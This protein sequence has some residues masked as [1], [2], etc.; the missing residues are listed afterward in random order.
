MMSKAA[1]K[2]MKM[3]FLAIEDLVPA[4]HLLR[5]LQAKVDF[6]FIYTKSEHLYSSKG[7]PSIDPVILIKALLIGYIYGI[8]SE[9]RLEQEIQVNMAYKLFLGL[10]I[11]E[12]PPDHSTMSQNR[13]RRFN[14]SCIFREIF[15]EI[16]MKCHQAGLIDGKTLLTDSTHVKANAASS[17]Y[18][19]KEIRRKLNSYIDELDRLADEETK[20]LSDRNIKSSPNKIKTL[21]P[22]N[23]RT[24]NTDPESGEV[25]RPGKPRGFHYLSHA[26][27]DSKRGIIVDIAVTGG[28]SSDISI[29]SERISYIKKIFNFDIKEAIGDSGYDRAIAHYLLSKENIKLYAAPIRE[30][31]VWKTEITRK[32]LIYDEQN[33]CFI[34]PNSKLLTYSNVERSEY[35]EVS[36]LYRTKTKDCKNC[37]YYEK[38]IAPS[39]KQKN[40]RVNVLEPFILKSRKLAETARFKELMRLR[41]II[42][43][44]NHALQ[45]EHHNLRFTRKRGLAKALEHCLFSA[46]ALNLKRLVKFA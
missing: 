4:E 25:N 34:C 30:K 2:Q 16:V 17:K 26:T 40:I 38:C 11:D 21:K 22:I 20:L 9:R 15:E 23:R 33:D 35:G 28:D 3:M 8:N 42:A 27:S 36:R 1:P 39:K 46:M 24:S 31:T 12:N 41:Q 32:D 29:Y 14:E 13:K 7:R 37:T 18:E 6:S 19:I 10:D 5:K 44:G 43:E 45:K